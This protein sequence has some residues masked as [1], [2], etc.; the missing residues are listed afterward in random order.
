MKGALRVSKETR[1]K[2]KL[3]G[4]GLLG[5]RSDSIDFEVPF[6]Y[7]TWWK[8]EQGATSE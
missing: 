8:K 2:S 7:M 3:L 4:S 5:K 1:E 6:V